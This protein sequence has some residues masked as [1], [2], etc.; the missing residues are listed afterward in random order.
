MVQSHLGEYGD[1]HTERV[2]AEWYKSGLLAATRQ[3]S[4][5]PG[6]YEGYVL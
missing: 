6:K 5:V 3:Q 2:Q 1:E 4:Q